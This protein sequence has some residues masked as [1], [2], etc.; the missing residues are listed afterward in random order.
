MTGVYGM[1]S[2]GLARTFTRAGVTASVGGAVLLALGVAS[3]VFLTTRAGGNPVGRDIALISSELGS[4]S[5]LKQAEG[6]AQL[7]GILA[8]DVNDY[9]VQWQSAHAWLPE[10]IADGHD[11]TAAK[12]ARREVLSH[13]SWTPLVGLWQEERVKALMLMGKVNAALRNA[14]SLFYVCTL[15]RTSS[16]LLLLQ[17]CLEK[18]YPHGKKLVN[19]FIDEQMAGAS[20]AGVSCKV[21]TLIKINAKPYEAVLQQ[22]HGTSQWALTEKM[23]LLLLSGHVRR[24]L[25]TAKLAAALNTNVRS[26][27][28]AAADV[29]R[30]MKAVDSTVY[31]ANRYM[32]AAARRYARMAGMH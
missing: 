20:K 32:L 4:R 30:A 16:A 15:R 9:G 22:I 7:K 6:M 8:H 26:Y 29:A 21:L 19:L 13:S 3:T 24:A 17:E 10:L 18:A 11:A 2:R 12:L 23:N 31:R 27:L 28:F 14:K 25:R 1:Q 5:A